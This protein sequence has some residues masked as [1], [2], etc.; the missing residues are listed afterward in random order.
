V[1]FS[2]D[3]NVEDK[4]T[5]TDA[6]GA[7]ARPLARETE[8]LHRLL[9]NQASEGVQLA[10]RQITAGAGAGKLIAVPIRSTPAGA[11]VIIGGIHYGTTPMTLDLS[12]GAHEVEIKLRGYAPWNYRVLVEPGRKVDAVLSPRGVR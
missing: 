4:K 2:K 3:F 10:L 7:P 8:L 6:S 12:L 9:T 5:Y 1:R 11:D